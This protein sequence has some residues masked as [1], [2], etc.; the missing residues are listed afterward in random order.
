MFC[1]GDGDG[2]GG[3]VK[4]KQFYVIH[5]S[6]SLYIETVNLSELSLLKSL[7]H[8]VTNESNTPQDY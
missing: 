6:C 1:F 5:C 2:N 3:L 8:V 7:L 4:T